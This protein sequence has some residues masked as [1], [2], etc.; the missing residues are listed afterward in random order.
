MRRAVTALAIVACSSSGSDGGGTY[1][2]AFPSTAA[3]VAA[4]GV[5]VLVFDASDAGATFCTDLVVARRS[6]QA[7]PKA[8]VE[9]KVVTPCDMVAGLGQVTIPFGLRAVLA[10]AQKGG[11]D[12]LIGCALQQVGSGDA[13][14][15]VQLA[16]ASTTVTVPATTCASLSDHCG[17]RCPK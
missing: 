5:Q 2:L 12:Y 13:Q 14:V 7:L 4:D 17:G 10:V 11:Q 15:P 16:L 6:S 3:A 9:S 8:L 1:T